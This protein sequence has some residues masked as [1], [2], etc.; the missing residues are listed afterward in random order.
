MA[1]RRTIGQGKHG[2]LL[3]LATSKP[4]PRGVVVG[5]GDYVS[6]FLWWL[7][8]RWYGC[9]SRNCKYYWTKPSFMAWNE[10]HESVEE[11]QRNERLGHPYSYT[12]KDGRF[13]WSR[14]R[15]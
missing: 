11:Y 14:S 7:R 1:R 2:L 13:Q 9:W 10:W 6:R 12:T 4:H 8:L 3:R 15:G 5:V